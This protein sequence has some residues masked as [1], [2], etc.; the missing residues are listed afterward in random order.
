M[1][2]TRAGQ[3]NQSGMKSSV[4]TLYLED[5]LIRWKHPCKLV[6][7]F[8]GSDGWLQQQCHT[9]ILN[10][11]LSRRLMVDIGDILLVS[12]DMVVYVNNDA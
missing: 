8:A 2:V 7:A 3:K 4:S 12:F 5:I 6:P 9:G 11:I 1:F 10:T